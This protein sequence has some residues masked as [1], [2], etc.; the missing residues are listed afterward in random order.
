M[1]KAI[2]LKEWIL[3]FSLIFGGCCSNFYALEELVR[4]V[5]QSGHLVT[6]SQ[7]I[8]VSLLGLPSHLSF[9]KIGGI[10][11]PNGLKP[12][13]VP[14][15]NWIVM[16]I[17]FWSVSILNNWALGFSIP[18]P[19]HII[20]RSGSLMVSML[21]GFL[22][23]SRT[24][25]VGK[26]FGVAIVTAGIVLSSLASANATIGGLEN[27]SEFL[28]GIFILVVAL[29]ISCLLGQYQQFVYA[30]YGKHWAEGLFYM[31]FLGLPPFLV[32]YRDIY[33][34]LLEYNS[35]SPISIG[36]WIEFALP[37]HL[38]E[39]IYFGI[40]GEFLRSVFLPKLWFFLILNTVTQ[41]ICISGVSKLTSMTSSV[42]VNLVLSIRKFVSLFLSIIIFNNTF[43]AGNIIG[44]ICV[45]AGTAIYSLH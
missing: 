5:P 11:L 25:S 38:S 20:F 19:F 44:A 8:F 14:L 29:I 18:V 12:R 2:F 24:F 27:T 3:V 17:L 23:F 30:K 36:E 10:T 28:T 7:F 45:F 22:F 16:V 21:M 26:I 43:T 13:A 33:Q 41:Y 35:S 39:A 31:H 32:F 6:L 9:I 34:V 40:G 15:S 4:S 42:T 1:L 37:G